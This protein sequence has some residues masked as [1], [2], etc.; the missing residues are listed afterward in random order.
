MAR[1][2]YKG[3]SSHNYVQNR[4]FLLTDIDIVKRDLMNHIHTR[5]GSRRMMPEYGTIIPEVVFELITPE[6]LDAIRQDLD[7]V[8]D[9]DPR[10][11]PVRIQLT[12]YDDQNTIYVSAELL[13]IEVNTV[14]NLEFN[15]TVET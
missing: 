2:I 9:A 15:I 14:D 10:V 8:F 13:F 12:P 5:K 4:T 7:V 3:Y 1:I 6:L 11:K